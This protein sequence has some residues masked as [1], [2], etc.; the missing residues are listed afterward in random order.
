VRV[1]RMLLEL[2]DLLVYLGSHHSVLHDV[3]L[4]GYGWCLQLRDADENGILVEHWWER[5]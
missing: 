4:D 5:H 3:H 1:E 2:A